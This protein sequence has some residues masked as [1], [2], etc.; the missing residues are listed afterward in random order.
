VKS[1]VK[2]EADRIN[3]LELVTLLIAH[4]TLR[5]RPAEEPDAGRGGRSVQQRWGRAPPRGAA[6]RGS[7]CAAVGAVC[8]AVSPRRA[9]RV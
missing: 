2:H 7:L 8:P 9:L 6:G 3:P 1:A 4:K 5:E